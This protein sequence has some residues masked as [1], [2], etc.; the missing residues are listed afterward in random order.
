MIITVLWALLLGPAFLVLVTTL[1]T[2][3]ASSYTVTQLIGAYR[4]LTNRIIIAIYLGLVVFSIGFQSL[5]HALNNS[6]EYVISTSVPL[7]EDVF[8]WSQ[9]VKEQQSPT[10]VIAIIGF[11]LLVVM[12]FGILLTLCLKSSP[13]GRSGGSMSFKL[14]LLNEMQFSTWEKKLKFILGRE[15]ALS[16]IQRRL[17]NSDDRNLVAYQIIAGAVPQRLARNVLLTENAYEAFD[18]LKKKYGKLCRDQ[19]KILSES[20]ERKKLESFD[21]DAVDK[22]V[23]AI[24]CYIT[25]LSLAGQEMDD[26]ESIFLLTNSLPQTSS[27][28]KSFTNG[29][30]THTNFDHAVRTFKKQC[31][32]WHAKGDSLQSTEP[33]A[34]ATSK[35]RV[36]QQP[37]ETRTCFNCSIRGH[38]A[39]DC[40]KPP[41]NVSQFRNTVAN[42]SSNNDN[43]QNIVPQLVK[44][45]YTPSQCYFIRSLDSSAF[46]LD[47]GSTN[48]HVIDSRRFSYL[49]ENKEDVTVAN[50]NV[51]Q[52]LGTG[53]VNLKAK[54][55]LLQLVSAK[56]TPVFG[57]NLISIRQLAKQGFSTI[58][59]D[60]CA[61]V[62]Y[63]GKVILI[64][65][66]QNHLYVYY[67]PENIAMASKA[68]S[69]ELHSQFGHP[70]K[71]KT[72]A[73]KKMYPTMPFE[74]VDNCK[75]CILANQTQRPYP[76]TN[77]N[78]Y[79]PLDVI[80]LDICDSKGRGYDNTYY[81][82]MMIDESSKY[83][84][85]VALKD[86]TSETVLK[87]F[88]KFQAKMERLL[89]KP[90]KR[91]RTDNGREFLGNFS[92][93]LEQK[94]IVHQTTTPYN[95]QSN[96]N[97]ERS[98]RTISDKIRVLLTGACM[99]HRYWPL[100]LRTAVF[101]YNIIPHSSLNESPFRKLFPSSRDYI[102]RGGKM[103]TFGCLA[104]KW[105]HPERRN[106]ARANKFSERSEKRVFVGYDAEDNDAFI[107]LDPKNDTLYRERNVRFDED[108]LPFC[109]KKMDQKGECVCKQRT[110]PKT[111]DQ[112][113]IISL[114]SPITEDQRTEPPAKNDRLKAETRLS[115]IESSSDVQIDTPVQD[116]TRNDP[117]LYSVET[118]TS[119]I[120]AKNDEADVLPLID[121]DEP[122]DP[123]PVETPEPLL[124][125]EPVPARVIV[126]IVD[127][128][129][130]NDD[131]R[132]D[133]K[134]TE[135]KPEG[136]NLRDRSTLKPPDRLTYLV[137]GPKGKMIVPKN[138]QEVLSSQWHNYWID[139]ENDELK[140]LLEN[141]TFD[142]VDETDNMKIISTK[143]VFDVKYTP[144]GKVDRFK[145]RCVA[146]GFEQREGI[147]Y[148]STFA[149]TAGATTIRTYITVCKVFGMQIHQL[150]VKTAFL[151]GK[152][153]RDLFVKPPPPFDTP[154]K[155]WKLKKSLYGLKQ[156]SFHWA[157]E[158]TSILKDI[159]FTATKTD[160]CVFVFNDNGKLCY[161]LAYV[162]DLLLAALDISTLE[163]V[164]KVLHEK[165][166]IRDLGHIRTFLNIDFEPDGD[167]SIELSQQRYIEAL[168][169]DF[170]LTGAS[171]NHK[172]PQ[173][174]TQKATDG[175]V[176]HDVPYRELLGGLN[177]IANWTRPDISAV[178][179]Y[180]SRSFQSPTSTHWEY[181]KQVLR[182]LATTKDKKLKL[183]KLDDSNL[184]AFS[185]ANYAPPGDECRKSQSGGVIRLCGSTIEWY[186][187]KQKTVSKSTT[188]SEYVAL[189]LAVDEVI[190][191]QQFLDELQFKVDLPTTVYEDCQPALAIA[192][193]K[194]CSA[195]SK[196]I[197]VRYHS[198][199]DYQAR[200]YVD[201]TYI[202]TLDQ[203]ADD[204]TKVKRIPRDTDILLGQK[205][206]NPESGGVLG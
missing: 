96:G 201:I 15:K 181:A 51:C 74:P 199:K 188:A 54:S 179:S 38:I 160:P 78:Q 152:L 29:L 8:K 35:G 116:S 11:L 187:R 131:V 53:T 34:M 10:D 111:I 192:T 75:T 57:V 169:D 44:R 36:Y 46:L 127:Q 119:E 174:D 139:A 31:Q 126:P 161:L 153:D 86:K 65:P 92:K 150:D 189:S 3:F 28:I 120:A 21:P 6:L 193:N 118:Q 19:I 198:T 148:D 72:F 1:V 30:N 109:N 166:N 175:K 110:E 191:L 32:E 70:G 24:Q 107:L 163:K 176:R 66:C 200:G 73:L 47:S 204:L 37:K 190:W 13:Q 156:A 95:H 171:Q 100:A 90:V 12:V 60:D 52:V 61:R 158:L 184:I 125:L 202:D 17:A 89:G 103:H 115:S 134:S 25:Q 147:D 149:A 144:E 45:Q 173:I 14:E 88:T 129:N 43:D 59:N 77:N 155:V 164:K 80:H 27:E 5:K 91:V 140:S 182:Y 172:L 154:G 180:L 41:R 105:I 168:V 49:D 84:E 16:A 79:S 93:Y 69:E 132:P 123:P 39:K 64:A 56:H 22:H 55:G 68:S 9:A 167:H 206:W 159:G 185:D 113:I 136:Y 48:H 58:F 62:C 165:F 106:I 117:I 112:G 133:T 121:F 83:V 94:G 33:L 99:P 114:D 71:N 186:S 108:I 183:G 178:V 85:A 137:D 18:A 2:C 135:M 196:H 151:Y 26:T 122:A 162:D 7:S 97:V 177:Y 4:E 63:Q 102:Q 197:E 67:E 87:Y 205:T 50:G 82:L 42:G 101:I 124:A 40:R 195:D 76:L 81:Y 194:K 20:I 143:W 98:I 23:D 138:H 141:D 128:E 104:Y 142:V 157:E 130:V 203:L 170:N 145:A 146:R